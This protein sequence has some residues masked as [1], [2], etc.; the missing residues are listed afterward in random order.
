MPNRTHVSAAGDTY[1]SLSTQYFGEPSQAGRIKSANPGTSFVFVPGTTV[2]IPSEDTGA[3]GTESEDLVMRIAGV[4]FRHITKVTITRQLDAVSTVEIVAP[5][6]ATA[7]FTELVQPLTFRSLEVADR[8]V[9]M[10]RGVMVSVVPALTPDKSQVRISG[11]STPGALGDCTAPASSYPIQFRNV[12]LADIAKEMAKPFSIEVVTVGDMGGPFRRVKAERDTKVLSFLATL[13]K[14]RQVLIRSDATGR[15]V[16]AAPPDVAA[17][18]ATMEQGQWPIKSV[19]PTFDPQK[20]YSHVTGLRTNRRGQRGGQY[21]VLNPRAQELGVVRPVTIPIRDVT[22]SE[23]PVATQAA[24]G[25]L[26]ANS[27]TYTVDVPTWYDPSDVAWN[28]GDTIEL[29]APSVFVPRPYKFQIRA[30][31]FERRVDGGDTASLLLMLPGAFGGDAPI[32][33]P[34]E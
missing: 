28:P 34:W 27:V 11:Y 17:P 24:A 1:E 16:L 22:R 31:R 4:T 10:F 23:L 7:A 15:M 8:G 13:A 6:A 33:L 25:R 14:Q 9:L 12:G 20:Y 18:V 26:L 3:A 2:I 32:M 5:Q 30:V 21:T 29:T 19:I